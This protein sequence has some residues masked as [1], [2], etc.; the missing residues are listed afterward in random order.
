MP[1]CFASGRHSE[2]VSQ[3][4]VSCH[5]VSGNRAGITPSFYLLLSVVSPE[6][7]SP[8]TISPKCCLTKLDFY[9]ILDR[10]KSKNGG[11]CLREKLDRLGLNL[12]AGRRKAANVTLLTSLVEGMTFTLLGEILKPWLQCYKPWLIL[13]FH[14]RSV[15]GYS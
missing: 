10:A 3:N 12:P 2:E 15:M 6:R 5:P 1:Q 13:L 11:R 14:S 7:S 4:P 9:L 8:L